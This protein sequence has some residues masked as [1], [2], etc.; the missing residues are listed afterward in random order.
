MTTILESDAATTAVPQ[1]TNR[2]G[3]IFEHSKRGRRG[4]RLPDLDV[5][6]DADALPPSL[7]RGEIVD[8]VEVSE[9]MS[10]GTSRGCRS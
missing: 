9:V 2:E 4:Y 10:S 3:L 8:E 6:E 1:S 5:P 7:R